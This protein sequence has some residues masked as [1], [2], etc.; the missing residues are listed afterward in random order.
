MAD[1]EIER[2]LREVQALE[3]GGRAAQPP[4]SKEPQDVSRPDEES[5]GRGRRS[6]A[7]VAAA[8][9]GGIGLI[10]GTLL[11][12]LPWVSGLST[13]LGAALGAALVALVSGPPDWYRK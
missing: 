13:G 9:G 8:A 2:L 6:W 3:S 5:G 10:V 12:I 7:L 1:D 11:S 4:S